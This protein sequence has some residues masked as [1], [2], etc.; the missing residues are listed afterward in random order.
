M[1]PE[2]LLILTHDDVL[3]QRWASLGSDWLVERGADLSALADWRAQGRRLVLLDGQ[4]PGLPAWQDAGWP[5]RLSGVEL[6][7]GLGTPDDQLGAAV[8]QAGA[9][10]FCHLYA[11]LPTVRQALQVVASGELWVGRDLLTRL[12]RLLDGHPPAQPARGAS[13]AAWAHGLTVRER[14]VAELA[15]LGEANDAIAERLGITARTVK[16]HLSTAFDKLGVAD[17]LQ[18][19]LRVHGIR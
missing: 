5:G 10:G 3:A 7:V 8:L 14:E 6:L 2:P 16:A 9:G 12:L 1:T 17:R 19:A 11:P 4:M 18:L 13:D 15:S